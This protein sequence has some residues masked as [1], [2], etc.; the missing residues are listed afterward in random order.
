MVDIHAQRIIEKTMEDNRELAFAKNLLLKNQETLEETIRQLN[1]SN[2]E[3]QQ[4]AY[5]ASHDL[6]EPVRKVLYYTDF[7][8]K[9]YNNAPWILRANGT[10]TISGRRA[11]ECGTSSWIC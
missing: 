4:F 2:H 1:R 8:L 10:F 5:I 7:L 6:Q 11:K 9:Q 3:L